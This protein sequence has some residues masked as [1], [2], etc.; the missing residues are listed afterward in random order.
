M[1]Q[2]Q[3]DILWML[4]TASLVFMMQGGFM[5]LESGFTRSKNSINVALKNF[6]DFGISFCLFWALG[7]GLMFGATRGGWVGTDSLLLPFESI[8]EWRTAFFF[9]AMF[10]ATAVTILSGAA[11]GTSY[12]SYSSSR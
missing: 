7:F 6:T 5:C 9:Q 8:G 3:S 12:L 10:C 1:S 2:E 4:V 11:A